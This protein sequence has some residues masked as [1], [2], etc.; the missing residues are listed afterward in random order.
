MKEFG[1]FFNSS[2]WQKSTTDKELDDAL[3]TIV[4]NA[5]KYK[6]LLEDSDEPCWN[7]FPVKKVN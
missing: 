7:S 4:A 2:T 3:K 1:T 6:E 5:K